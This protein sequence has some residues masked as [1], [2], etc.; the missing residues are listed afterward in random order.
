[1]VRRVAFAL[2]MIWS[3]GACGFDPSPAMSTCVEGQQQVCSCNDGAHGMRQCEPSS[4]FGECACSDANAAVDAGGMRPDPGAAGSSTGTGGHAG[5]GAT[6]VN[7]TAGMSGAAGDGSAGAGRAGM[8]GSAGDG[9]SAGVDGN[10]G[11]GGSGGAA[12]GSSGQG[13]DGEPP[14]PGDPYTNCSDDTDCN[15]G[16]FC[17]AMDREGRAVGYCTSFCDAANGGSCPQPTTGAVMATCFPF[18][19]LCL[20]GTC[21]SADCPSGMRC[22]ESSSSG[23]G[24]PFGGSGLLV[25]E[26]AR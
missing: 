4:T 2:S 10:A 7:A 20:L 8:G 13:G 25:C 16:L 22:V 14:D 9:G 11:S 12:G 19:S 3:V 21:D 17:A 26:Y 15:P 5:S 24:G 18:A 23:S 6:G 1:M